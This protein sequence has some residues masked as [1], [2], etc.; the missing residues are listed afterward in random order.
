[1]TAML[2]RPI[3]M[4]LVEDNAGDARLVRE[5]L[6]DAGA[7]E[8]TLVQVAR[9][10]AALE[11]LAAGGIDVV[12]LDLLLP[13]ASGLETVTRVK[14]AAPD[15]P[16]LV[17][18]GFSDEALALQAV[19][20]G[21]QDYLVKGQLDGAALVRG[22]R[23]A[24]ERHRML[25][26]LEQ[27]RR[28]QLE[29]K[30]RLLSHVSHELRTPLNAIDGFVTLVLNGVAGPVTPEQRDY[31]RIAL[32]SVSRLSSMI[33]DLLDATRAESGK[34]V[35]ERRR[36]SLTELIGDTVETL[37]PA[38]EAKGLAL[39][40]AALPERSEIHAD[41]HRV[42]QVLTN[43]VDNAI[44]FTAEGTITIAA[45]VDDDPALLRVSVVDTGCGI[46]P[47]A[48]ERIFE[49][50][51][52]EGGPSGAGRKGLGLGLYLCKALVAHQ[53]GTIWVE[54]RVGS[55]ST[56]HFTLPR[57]SAERGASSADARGHSEQSPPARPL[58]E[59][60]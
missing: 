47:G 38:A 32:K 49:R 23:Y 25:L 56:F 21:A 14:R 30:D 37:R 7:A 46:E 27:T 28:Q 18:T 4:L 39:V 3:R 17:L 45:R 53:G 34:L 16:I 51:H 36:A 9:L 29:L 2:G 60:I 24:L 54:S 26:E 6:S 43:L 1:M 12:L 11:C 19:R 42:Q 48:S 13:D 31:L 50:L 55:G 10:A 59:S 20:S 15:V 35:I 58:E 33:G 41:P 44:K 57:F 8:I 5:A 22:V 40:V 52:Q